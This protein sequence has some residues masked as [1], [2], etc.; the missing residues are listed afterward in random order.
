MQLSRASSTSCFA[1]TACTW[2]FSERSPSASSLCSSAASCT[3]RTTSSGSTLDHG[4]PQ[5]APP[6]RCQRSAS[7]CARRQ[8]QTSGHAGQGMPPCCGS[9]CRQWW[10]ACN[11]FMGV[12]GGVLGRLAGYLKACGQAALCSAEACW[13]PEQQGPPEEAGYASAL[14][15]CQLPAAGPGPLIVCPWC[16]GRAGPAGPLPLFVHAHQCC[17]AAAC[18][19]VCK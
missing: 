17:L 14:V 7:L 16:Q 19:R 11:M 8:Y 5:G 10:H 4:L 9:G 18:M 3:A 1:G 15:G 2:V 13:A 12:C 6:G